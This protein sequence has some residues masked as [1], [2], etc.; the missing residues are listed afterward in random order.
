MI[1]TRELS[2]SPLGRTICV[3]HFIAREITS[4]ISEK[5]LDYTVARRYIS[6]KSEVEYEMNRNGGK[7]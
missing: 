3:L 5:D 6:S 4:V 1:Q 7:N 2:M